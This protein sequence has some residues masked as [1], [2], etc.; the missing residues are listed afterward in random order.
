MSRGYW[1][2]A[3]AG[4]MDNPFIDRVNAVPGAR[5][6]HG[7]RLDGRRLQARGVYA[8]PTWYPGLHVA[9]ALI[10]FEG[11]D[12]M[13]RA[14]RHSDPLIGYES[15]VVRPAEGEKTALQLQDAL[16][17]THR[18]K[19]RYVDG[20]DWVVI[21]E[22]DKTERK[23]KSILASVRLRASGPD[24]ALATAIMFIQL[25]QQLLFA[26]LAGPPRPRGFFGRMLAKLR[27]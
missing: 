19:V 25:K 17:T 16:D 22:F 4:I 6:R 20:H 7:E 10:V 9:V 24:R 15:D 5:E 11:G 8:N 13:V 2:R 27:R 26:D 21:G 23:F 14:V 18:L 1:S 3:G 12:Y